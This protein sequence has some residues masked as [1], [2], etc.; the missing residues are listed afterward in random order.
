MTHQ[1]FAQL[2]FKNQCM[3]LR[4]LAVLV[5]DRNDHIFNYYLFQLDSFYIEIR[6][7]RA[8][9]I[10]EELVSFSDV[11]FIERYLDPINIYQLIN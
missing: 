3:L 1:I 2:Q 11:K 9:N 7:T 10:L 4:D 6:V 8:G 5:A